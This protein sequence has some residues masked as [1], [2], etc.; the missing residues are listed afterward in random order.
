MEAVKLSHQM[1]NA[2]KWV[3]PIGILMMV[4]AMFLREREW[5]GIPYLVVLFAFMIHSL[6]H[7]KNEKYAG[8]QHSASAM[9]KRHL[10]LFFL[11][12]I[13][14]LLAYLLHA[15]PLLKFIACSTVSLYFAYYKLSH[16]ILEH[17]A[18]KYF[19]DLERE[20]Q[21]RLQQVR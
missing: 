18:D 10:A 19:F 21:R 16:L 7:F 4:I 11:F 12:A 5:L 8:I 14:L 13:A 2:L 20:I 15:P 6:V 9:L 1:I 17:M 3:L